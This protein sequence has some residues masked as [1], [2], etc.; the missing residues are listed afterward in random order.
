MTSP[1]K[2]T[3]ARGK[4]VKRQHDLSQASINSPSNF[5]SDTDD[6]SDNSSEG[7][8]DIKQLR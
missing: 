8:C 5:T 1:T 2:V 7:V 4:G 6:S 3:L